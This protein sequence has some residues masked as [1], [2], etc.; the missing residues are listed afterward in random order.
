M[1]RFTKADIKDVKYVALEVALK[2][3]KDNKVKGLFLGCQ[4]MVKT[5]T[6]L[7][8]NTEEFVWLHKGDN[9]Y[10]LNVAHYN[11]EIIEIQRGNVLSTYTAGNTQKEYIERLKLIQE[12]FTEDGNVLKDGL[13]DTDKY[14]VPKSVLDDLEKE[15]K[16]ETNTTKS[17]TFNRS[18]GS[19]YN[20]RTGGCNYSPGY[21]TYKKKEPSTSVIKRTTK[22]PISSAINRMKAKVDELRKGKYEPPKLPTIPAD[23]EPPEKGK[24]ADEDDDMY[25]QMGGMMG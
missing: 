24:A 1:V 20:A 9:V 21:N 6:Q 11:V 5:H 8:A 25:S 2:R 17:T 18:G 19:S 15:G 16:K 4:P 12:V 10:M 14:T 23:K 13:I 22:Y 7:V 3:D